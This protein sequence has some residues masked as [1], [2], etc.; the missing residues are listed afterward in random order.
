MNMHCCI[1]E[2]M[3]R[4]EMSASFQE[5]LKQQLGERLQSLDEYAYEAMGIR[6][7]TPCSRLGKIL[8]GLFVKAA[9]GPDYH[10][11]PLMPKWMRPQSVEGSGCII[12]IFLI[13]VSVLLSAMYAVEYPVFG[14][15][16]LSLLVVSVVYNVVVRV[17]MKKK[18]TVLHE[19]TID[20]MNKHELDKVY[21]LLDALKKGDLSQGVP[22]L[23]KSGPKARVFASF[24]A[25]VQDLRKE[26]HYV[27]G[28]SAWIF[29]GNDFKN[30]YTFLKPISRRP[31][32]DSSM[33]LMEEIAAE[34]PVDAV[35]DAVI[36]SAPIP[37]FS[38]HFDFVWSISDRVPLPEQH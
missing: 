5:R 29:D 7:S 12:L 3:E 15:T 32:Q 17:R 11:E 38:T 6:S 18:M 28:D 21:V 33:G 16:Y 24:T 20:A 35:R 22:S 9:E 8:G 31:S 23:L 19:K 37:Y 14:I 27:A 26:F 10:R 1:M 34:Y 30:L 4:Y 25:A 13:M 2:A 36:R